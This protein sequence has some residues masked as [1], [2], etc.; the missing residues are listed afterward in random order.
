MTRRN[1]T[2]IPKPSVRLDIVRLTQAIYWIVLK[3]IQDPILIYTLILKS[4][5]YKVELRIDDH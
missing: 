5:Y 3:N 1:S 2:L 4:D